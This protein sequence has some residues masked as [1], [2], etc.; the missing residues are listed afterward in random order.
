VDELPPSNPILRH[1]SLR[2]AAGH[3]QAGVALFRY[4]QLIERAQRLLSENTRLREIAH[5]LLD[6]RLVRHPEA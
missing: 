6:A 4:W 2:A 1:P 5:D 3:F